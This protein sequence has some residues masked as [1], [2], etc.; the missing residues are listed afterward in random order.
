MNKTCPNYKNQ[1]KRKKRI[2]NSDWSIQ[3]EASDLS[4]EKTFMYDL[5]EVTREAMQVCY[6]NK[7]SSSLFTVLMPVFKT[8]H[9]SV[10][11]EI[12]DSLSSPLPLLCIILR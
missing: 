9:R 8:P 11:L 2:N 5:V 10:S 7:I 12:S 4:K 3:K 6:E 1:D